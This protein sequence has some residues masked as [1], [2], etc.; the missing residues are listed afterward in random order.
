MLNALSGNMLHLFDLNN[1]TVR[2]NELSLLLY[3][4]LDVSQSLLD[5]INPILVNGTEGTCYY[6]FIILGICLGN[7]RAE[8]AALTVLLCVLSVADQGS[9][10]CIKS[11]H[12]IFP[13]DLA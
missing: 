3:R 4:L 2:A 7:S 6:N 10:I 11:I 1:L 9:V 12:K 5:S 13:F 8:R